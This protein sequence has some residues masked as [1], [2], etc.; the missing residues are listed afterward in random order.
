MSNTATT[1]GNT[2]MLTVPKGEWIVFLAD[3]TRRNRGAHGRLEVLGGEIGYQVE[4]EDRPFDGLAADVKDR[5]NTVWISFGSTP[6]DHLTHGVHG[7]VAL[8]TLPASMSSGEV[9]AVEVAD[10]SKTVLYL[11]RPE[12]FALPPAE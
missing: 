10:G 2:L 1:I 4:T 11:S 6:A 12:D 8:Y 7:A 3:F 9:F 5:E